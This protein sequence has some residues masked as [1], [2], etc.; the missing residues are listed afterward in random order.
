MK[1]Y[2]IHAETPLALALKDNKAAQEQLLDFV[3]QIQQGMPAE[4]YQTH[5]F[6]CI[7]QQIIGWEHSQQGYDL[8]SLL[9]NAGVT[10]IELEKL[11]E[12]RPDLL[13]TY[14]PKE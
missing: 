6:A 13:I 9:E 7:L 5:M 11:R 2:I 10:K 8:N 1:K 3:Q 4:A 12:E 14:E